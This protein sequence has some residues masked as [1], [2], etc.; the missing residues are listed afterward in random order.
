MAANVELDP[1]FRQALKFLHSSNSDAAENIRKSLDEVIKQKHG[2]SKMLINTLSKKYIAEESKATG[3]GVIKAVK[4]VRR[5]SNK[6]SDSSSNNSNSSPVQ[7]ISTSTASSAVLA[8][9]DLN[10][11]M[12]VI[13]S[14]PDT[15]ENEQA[16]TSIDDNAMDNN[17]HDS[18]FDDLM[19]VICRRIDLSAKNRLI[20]CTKCNSL[21]HQDCHTPQIKDADLVNGQELSWCCC[22]CS[23][24]KFKTSSNASPSNK[25]NHSS[26]SSSSSSSSNST[27]MSI[28]N[29]IASSLVS[30]TAHISKKSKDKEKDKEKEKE[31]E[32]DKEKEKEKDKDKE[33]SSSSKLDKFN[34]KEVHGSFNL[35][36]FS[37]YANKGH[38]HGKDEHRKSS[39]SSSSKHHSSSSSSS[40]HSS[41]SHKHEKEKSSSSKNGSSSSSSKTVTPNIHVISADKRLQNM[42][43]KAKSQESKRK[44]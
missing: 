5:S 12:P 28:S 1:V 4:N 41:S 18:F 8:T 24:K 44:K 20:E 11:E 29:I 39:K 6:S 19:C 32:K 13:I 34:P 35:F 40:H 37:P 10:P 7:I 16:I 22:D 17:I 14:I 9:T 15:E 31:K 36:S 33:S 27:S 43:K 3:S 2:S 26:S 21:Y 23:T 30:N 25:S 38:H 42:K